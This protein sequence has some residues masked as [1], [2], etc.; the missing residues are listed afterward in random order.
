MINEVRKNAYT[1]VLNILYRNNMLKQLNYFS[2]EAYHTDSLKEHN[3]RDNRY[4]ESRTHA[5]YLERVH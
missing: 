4:M 3:V 2:S 5:C 1:V